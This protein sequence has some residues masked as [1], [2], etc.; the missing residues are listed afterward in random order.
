MSDRR[1]WRDE[2]ACRGMDPELFHNRPEDSSPGH[3]A[4]TAC[5][6]CPVTR[7]CLLD[8][9]LT[10][11]SGLWGGQWLIG[12]LE[13]GATLTTQQSAQR[14]ATAV[15][16]LRLPGVTPA[17][18]AAALGMWSSQ[19]SALRKSMTVHPDGVVCLECG[20]RFQPWRP[21]MPVA[22]CSVG[23]AA[24]QV[25]KRKTGATTT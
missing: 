11:S 8:G 18:V 6:D 5:A 24:R 4:E 10:G 9:V 3:P 12:E 23:C 16:L 25:H 15:A 20:V 14:R 19:I 1:D 17:T 22:T 13:A 2:A 7:A 21:N